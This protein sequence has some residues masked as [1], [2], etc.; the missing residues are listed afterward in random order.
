MNNNNDQTIPN[1]TY[2]GD[3]I[4]SRFLKVEDLTERWGVEQIPV[5]ICRVAKVETIPDA[6]HIDPETKKPAIVMQTVLYFKNRAGSE[7]HRG[8]LLTAKE[9]L[10]SLKSATGAK[11]AGELIGKRILIFLS[12]FRK[13]PVLR[14]APTPPEEPEPEQ[15]QTQLTYRKSEGAPDLPPMP[16]QK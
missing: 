5:T 6:K 2:I 9:D 11:N 1:N 4:P 16:E 13:K 8:Y 3:L 14:I 7:F 15:K 12:E 10:E